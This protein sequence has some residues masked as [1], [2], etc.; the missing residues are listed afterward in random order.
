MLVVVDHDNKTFSVE[1]PMTDDT[2]WISAV[3]RAQDAGR[4][5]RCFSANLGEYD[6]GGDLGTGMKK[7]P[8]GSIVQV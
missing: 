3:S 2:P 7:M 8:P 4:E 5:V 6:E 1:G